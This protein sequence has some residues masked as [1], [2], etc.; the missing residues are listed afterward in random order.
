MARKNLISEGQ[1]RQWGKLAQ[2]TP[3]TENFIDE[4]ADEFDEGEDVTEG[5]DDTLEEDNFD[6]TGRG[7]HR[8]GAGKNGE[9]KGI[10]S[11][12]GKEVKSTP[13]GKL[14]IPGTGY[15]GDHKNS[16]KSPSKGSTDG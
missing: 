5:A 7:P 11:N 13:D 12:Q 14:E 8:E 6:K 4:R 15:A 1:V 9:Q 10:A 2:I 16:T 3:L